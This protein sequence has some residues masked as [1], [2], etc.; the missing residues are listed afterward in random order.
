MLRIEP[1]RSK[2]SASP[3]LWSHRSSPTFTLFY[4]LLDYF[5][6]YISKVIPFPG[7]PI[8][9]TP[10]PSSLPLLLWRCSSTHP[11]TPTYPP[12]IHLPWGIYL[13]FIEQRTIDRI[14]VLHKTKDKAIT[15]YLCSWSQVYF[16]LDCLV[17]G[18]SG[19]G[20]WLVDIVV[21]PV[22]LQTT[23]TPSVLYWGLCAQSNNWLQ[24]SASV[25]VRFWQ[26]FSGDSYIRL[27]S[28][29]TSWY[30]Q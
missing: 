18:S 14:L 16:L 26:G 25:F 19:V 21:F 24:A 4:I 27:L 7:F 30:P 5:F 8:P 13:A 1:W 10:I 15:C 6:I 11:P 20:V 17:P 29:C 9:E 22:G 12:L 2:S 23:S 28:A 3:L